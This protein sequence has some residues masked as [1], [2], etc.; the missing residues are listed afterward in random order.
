VA[1]EEFEALATYG[2][3]GLAIR[4]Q[5][6]RDGQARRQDVDSIGDGI[7]ELRYRHGS[8]QFRLLFMFW[9]PHLVALTAFQKKQAKTPKQDCDRAH[10]RARRWREVFGAEP[11]E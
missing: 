4:M 3:A 11:G 1:Q 10:D 9:G 5:R 8:E 2:R 6:Y 7:F